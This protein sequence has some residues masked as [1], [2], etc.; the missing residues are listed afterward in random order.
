MTVSAFYSHSAH[1]LCASVFSLGVAMFT[2]AAQAADLPAI[3]AST[4]NTVTACVTPGRLM[5]YLKARTP[6]LDGRFE[7]VGTEYMRYGERLGVRWDYAFFQMIVE[8]GGLTFKNGNRSGDVKPSQFN[9]AG[10]G[11]TGNGEPGETFPDLATGVQ[12]HLQHILL[13]SG[14]PVQN[15]VAERTRKVQEWGVLTSW[16]KGFKQRPIT[17]ADLA[18]KWAPKSKTY[19]DSLES[20]ADKFFDDVCQKPDPHPELV[21]EAR[22]ESTESASK[23]AAVKP[24]KPSS[25]DLARKAIEDGKAENQDTRSGLGAMSVAKAGG[26]TVKILN[27]KASEGALETAPQK[28]AVVSPSATKALTPDKAATQVAA[29]AGAAKSAVTAPLAA[30]Q[31]CRVW[32]A[33]YG[34]QKSVI[35][36]SIIDGVVNFTVLDVNEGQETREAEAFIAAYAK[37]GELAGEYPA[38]AAALDKAFDLCPEG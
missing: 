28:V 22:G 17:F 19:A 6:D 32:T 15:P 11:A 7:T 20:V 26:A 13:Y 35:I 34:G 4:K 30:G 1:V 18:D 2:G 12:A 25:V 5:A 14:A 31:K 24:T 37:G 27:E 38:Q 29:A 36:R 23:I 3:K 10:L 33:S 9:L 21:A 8:T 16:Q